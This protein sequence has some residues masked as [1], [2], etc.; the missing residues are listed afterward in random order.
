MA[1]DDPITPAPGLEG[2]EL[3]EEVG[4]ILPEVDRENFP[5]GDPGL[6]QVM[7]SADNRTAPRGHL[8]FHPLGYGAA[9]RDSA[10][11]HQELAIDMQDADEEL[12]EDHDDFLDAFADHSTDDTNPRRDG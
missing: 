4:R 8:F 3:A 1:P 9:R 5:L 11:A 6:F 7:P 10:Y 2:E 12:E